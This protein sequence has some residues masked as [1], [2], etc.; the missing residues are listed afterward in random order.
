MEEIVRL[1]V[2]SVS[3]SLDALQQ[4]AAE[5]VTHVHAT[6]MQGNR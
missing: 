1:S 4:A 3:S 6:S 2:N 5:P